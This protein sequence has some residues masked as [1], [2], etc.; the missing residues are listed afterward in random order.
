MNNE[1][2]AATLATA[3]AG[4]TYSTSSSGCTGGRVGA[5]RERLMHKT[6]SRTDVAAATDEAVE[7]PKVAVDEVEV[8]DVE[9]A[10][11]TN[12]SVPAVVS[13]HKLHMTHESGV[14]IEY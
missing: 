4:G 1:G 3:A 7:A 14:G 12:S 6:R 10:A 11:A 13:L 2:A 9:T 8:D 5:S